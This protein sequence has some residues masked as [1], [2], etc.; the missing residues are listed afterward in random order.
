MLCLLLSCNPPAEKADYNSLSTGLLSSCNEMLT[1][2]IVGDLFTPPAASRI[3]AYSNVAFY[4]ALLLAYPGYA[5]YSGQLNGMPAM[6]P[7]A[8]GMEYDYSASA[9]FAFTEWLKNSSSASR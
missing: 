7:P 4:M 8:E 3:Y 6:P 5:T 1:D 9:A 2:A